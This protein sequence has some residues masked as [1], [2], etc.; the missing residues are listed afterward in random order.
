MPY[1]IVDNMKKMNVPM[2]MRESLSISGQV[3]MLKKAL[4]GEGMYGIDPGDEK[5]VMT[6]VDQVKDANNMPNT[7]V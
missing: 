5:V 2:T 6:N 1:N 3:D 4:S 7:I